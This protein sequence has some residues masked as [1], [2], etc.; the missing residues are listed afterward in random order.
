MG[1]L[2]QLEEVTPIIIRT[3]SCRRPVRKARIHWSGGL[4]HH[5]I[6]IT[7]GAAFEQVHYHLNTV[8]KT[9][10]QVMTRKIW[11]Q[12]INGMAMVGMKVIHFNALLKI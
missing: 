3:T 8:I 6:N 2:R 10:H 11:G 4:S 7:C 1:L 12:A 5:Y 9:H